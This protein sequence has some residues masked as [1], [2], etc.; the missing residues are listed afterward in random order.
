MAPFQSRNLGAL[1]LVPIQGDRMSP[2][3]RHG[4]DAVYY[5]RSRFLA[6]DMYVI[7]WGDG[8]IVTYIQ[9]AGRG[10]YRLFGELRHYPDNAVTRATLDQILL[11][12]VV[13]EITVRDPEL[14]RQA[15]AGGTL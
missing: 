5:A 1:K 13:C 7:D 11:G 12:V 10:T 9:S 3:L 15:V 6:D 14:F 8:P 4:R 2:R